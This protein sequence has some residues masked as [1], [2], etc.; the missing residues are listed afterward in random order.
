MQ[1][2]TVRLLLGLL[3]VATAAGCASGPERQWMKPGPYTSA[4]FRRDTEACTRGRELDAACMEAKGWIAV[5]A[6]K[7]SEKKKERPAYTTP[8]Y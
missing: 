6:E 7:E 4:D 5:Q 1:A 2:M 8:R 3:V